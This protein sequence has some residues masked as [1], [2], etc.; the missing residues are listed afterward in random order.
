MSLLI[1]ISGDK[2]KCRCICTKVLGVMSVDKANQQCGVRSKES[3]VDRCGTMLKR[4]WLR[5]T[6][7]EV[8]IVT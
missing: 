1:S 8:V 2:Y 6:A 7:E 5:G 4:A 3:G